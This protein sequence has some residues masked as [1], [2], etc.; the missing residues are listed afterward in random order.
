MLLLAIAVTVLVGWLIIAPWTPRGWIAGLSLGFL[1]GAGLLSLQMLLY[2]VLHLPW[3]RAVLLLPWVPLA[4]VRL[5]RRPRFEFPR[6]PDW[7]ET[8]ALVALLAAPLLWFPYERVMPLTTRAWDAWAI[9]LF[10]A[11]AFFLDGNTQAFFSRAGGFTAQ[12]AYPLLVPLYGTFLYTMIGAPADHLAKALSPC[13]FFSLLGG[14]YALARRSGPRPVALVFTAMLANLHM[15]NIVAFELAG[16]AD[17]ALS[18]YVLLG[19]GFIFYWLRDQQPADLALASLFSS[20][21]AWT[22]NEGLFFLAGAA[23]ILGIALARERIR[24]WRRGA[25]L[26]V[27][28]AV[29]VIPWLMLRR[30]WGIVALDLWQGGLQPANLLPGVR[31]I[32]SKVASAGAYNLTFPMLLVSLVWFRRAGLDIRWCAMPLLVFWQLLGLLAAYLS[33]RNEIQWWIGTSLDRILAQLA[34]LALLA[35]AILAGSWAAAREQRRAATVDSQL[36]PPRTY[37]NL[38]S[39]RSRSQARP[40]HRTA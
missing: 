33:N 28:P 16:Y 36:T 39:K 37:R 35:T 17:T 9:W 24:D 38:K 32:L 6:R 7:L 15:V 2:S 10:K 31:S 13:F 8:L 22:K 26:L 29:A 19:A 21:A 11:K 3:G 4:I 14:F 1:A 25:V 34:P 20:L 27:W 5:R 40:G 18:A 12:P 30:V 23:T